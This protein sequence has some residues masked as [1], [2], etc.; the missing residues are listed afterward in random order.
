SVTAFADAQSVLSAIVSVST[1]DLIILDWTL[2]RTTGLDLLQHLRRVGITIPV[3]FLTGRSLIS[4]ESLALE[5][6]AIDFID[7]S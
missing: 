7:K 5:H 6:G 4:N 2:P 1:A 3:V